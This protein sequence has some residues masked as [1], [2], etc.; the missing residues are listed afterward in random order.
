MSAAPCL[1]VT[2]RAKRNVELHL[3][4]H[5][6]GLEGA[7]ANQTDEIS[8]THTVSGSDVGRLWMARCSAR[9]SANSSGMW[10]YALIHGTPHRSCP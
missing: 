6:D 5:V 10:H 4:D 2:V 7:I 3:K 8:G 1:W 9:L